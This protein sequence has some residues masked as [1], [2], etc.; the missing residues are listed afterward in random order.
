[1]KI[2]INYKNKIHKYVEIKHYTSVQAMDQRQI[3]VQ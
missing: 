3:K 2:E 1:M